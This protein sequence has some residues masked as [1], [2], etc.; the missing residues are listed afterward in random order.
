MP[1]Q[2]FTT[3]GSFT[4]HAPAGVTSVTAQCWGAGGGGAEASTGTTGSG[5]G[6]GGGE[7]AQD[8]VGVT[9]T[10]GYTVT[11]GAAGAAGSGSE[12]TGNGAN[13]GNGGNS[14]FVGDASATVLAHGGS[15][16]Q[17]NPKPTG[18]GPG[19]AGGSGSGNT[20]HFPGGPGGSGSSAG[21]G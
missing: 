8:T 15:G 14:S 12:G 2:I 20:I 11:V 4:W 1:S 7:F 13:G 10:S 5:G 6:G 21:R 16:G 18:T 19:G 3:A 9:P 17:F